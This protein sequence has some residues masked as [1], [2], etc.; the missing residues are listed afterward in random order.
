M[1][2]STGISNLITVAAFSGQSKFSQDF[3]NILIRSVG[4]QSIA[5]NQIQAEQTADTNRQ[6]DL[7]TLDSKFSALQNAVT[8]LGSATGFASLGASVQNTSVASISLSPGASPASYTLE[9][10]NLGAHSQSISSSGLQT[11]TD[12]NSQDISS[13]SSFSL[14]VNGVQTQITPQTNSLQSLANAINSNASLGVSASIVNVGGSNSPDYR[15][16]LQSTALGNVPIQLNDGTQDLLTSVATGSLATY[17]VDGLPNPI[18]SSSDTITLAPGVSATL[19]GTNVGSPT[20][21]TVSQNTTALQSALQTLATAYNTAVDQF[22]SSY[23]QSANSLQGDSVLINAKQTLQAINGF[24][25]SDGSP[26]SALGLDL[27]T[28]GHLTF[29]ASEFQATAS[30]GFTVVAQLLGDSISG[31][32]GTAT[33]AIQNLEDPTTGMIKNE[34]QQ[35]ST[36]LTNLGTKINDQVNQINNFQQN[37]LAQLATADAAIYG[38]QSQASYFQSLFAAQYPTTSN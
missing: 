11:V 24:T 9:V 23:G 1:S 19:L 10:Q 20:T 15:L 21:I 32:I 37:L 25:G 4:I 29:N 2:S 5:L 17:M 8:A 28:S 12:P 16:S 38:L 18:S 30:Q 26:L 3:Q 31:F 33:S 34:E 6:Y 14:T 22:N 35:I 7:Q 13:A 27:D 36:S